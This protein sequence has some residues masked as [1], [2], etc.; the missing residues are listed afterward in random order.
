[1]VFGYYDVESTGEEPI[2]YDLNAYRLITIPYQY[3]SDFGR[4]VLYLGAFE[5]TCILDWE[6][7]LNTKDMTRVT[8]VDDKTYQ[9]LMDLVQMKYVHYYKDLIGFTMAGAVNDIAN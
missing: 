4:L 7:F 8:H 5:S 3:Y 1:M 9:M 6:E 2:V